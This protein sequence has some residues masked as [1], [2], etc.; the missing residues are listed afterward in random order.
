MTLRVQVPNAGA[1]LPGE[2]VTT[3]L[4]TVALRLALSL[5]PRTRLLCPGGSLQLEAGPAVAGV[6]Y[7]WQDG[8]GGTSYPVRGAGTYRLTAR[9]AQGCQVEDSVVV[10]VAPRPL[11]ALGPDTLVC[12][13]T[14]GLLLRAAAQPPGSTYRWQDGSTQTTYRATQPGLYTL[15]VTNAAGCQA[16]AQV[17][18][19]P[20]SCPLV[21]PNI[22][23]PN[24][25]AY[26]D[27]WVLKGVEPTEYA[28]TI[29]SR[30]G[31]PVYASRAYDNRWRAADIAGGIYYYLVQ[32]VR[33]GQQYKGWLEVVK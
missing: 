33:T 14:P 27:Y 12:S 30:W 29:Y 1:G 13:L 19:G 16:S 21:I 32:H 18:A 25:D 23:T 8:T 31:R 20:R 7:R 26:N 24:D 4:V 11:V 28:V 5:A 6:S 9:T 2:V 3:M 17:R 10:S 22:I 15:A